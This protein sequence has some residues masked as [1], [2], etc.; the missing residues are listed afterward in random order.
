MPDTR[1]AAAGRLPLAP[2]LPAGRCLMGRGAGVRGRQR[3]GA[4]PPQPQLQRGEYLQNAGRHVCAKRRWRGRGV[5]A[6]PRR[7]KTM[8]APV[9]MTP[10]AQPAVVCPTLHH[11]PTPSPP[12]VQARMMMGTR[13]RHQKLRRPMTGPLLP[14]DAVHSPPSRNTTVS[15]CTTPPRTADRGTPAAVAAASTRRSR[16]LDRPMGP[17]LP[18]RRS[19]AGCDR[20]GS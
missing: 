19:G 14:D 20:V 2:P 5:A 11:P 10:P 4:A 8:A 3:G 7:A 13:K 18:H 9:H 17:K 15:H 16:S 6:P 12:P 1:V